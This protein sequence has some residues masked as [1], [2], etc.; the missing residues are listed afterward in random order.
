MALHNEIGTL[1]ED[2]ACKYL[3]G[4][5]YTIRERNWRL[6]DIE[7]DVIAENQTELVLVEVKTRTTTFGDV[8]PEQYVDEH[9]RR[10]MTVAGNAYL[11][12]NRIDKNLRFDICGILWDRA[13]NA[14]K[15]IHY[16]ENAFSP[17]LRTRNANS[18]NGQWRWRRR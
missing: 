18:F 3:T 2:A 1:G 10:F 15:E 13:T 7:I 9:K 4:Q 11:K 17:K 6:G 5:G 16:Y 14:A 8:N 12:H